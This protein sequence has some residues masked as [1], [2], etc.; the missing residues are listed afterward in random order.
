MNLPYGARLVSIAAASFFAVN[1]AAGAVSLALERIFRRRF[2][3]SNPRRAAA[4]MLALRLAPGALALA[5][6]AAL[7]VP[8]FLVLEPAGTSESASWAC[9]IMASMGVAAAACGAVRGAGAWLGSWRRFRHFKSRRETVR[10]GSR[11][12]PVEIVESR[13][14][15]LALIGVARPRLVATRAVLRA[16]KPAELDVALR[17]ERAHAEFRD[18]AK[19]LLMAMAPAP[20]PFV[21]RSRGL[22]ASWARYVERAADDRA[23]AGSARR[24]VALAAALVRVARLGAAAPAP[25]ATSLMGDTQDLEARVERLLRGGSLAEASTAPARLSWLWALGAVVSL[26]AIGAAYP[27]LLT[28]VHELLERFMN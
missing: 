15:W 20:I 4:L 23:V 5:A 14:P 12:V 3:D 26:A 16:L 13:R 24:S 18:N 22:E 25:L 1:L 9:L 19:R 2:E 7:C 8:S 28:A 21:V 6:V 10:V 17:H 11:R 27:A